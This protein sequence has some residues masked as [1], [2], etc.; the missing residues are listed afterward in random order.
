VSLIKEASNLLVGFELSTDA[1]NDLKNILLSGQ[2]SD[3]YWT[4]AWNAFLA[5]PSTENKNI[6]QTRLQ[7]MFQRLLQLGEF[8]LM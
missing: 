8:Q 6:I 3:Y 1:V 4:N 5:N 2:Q 7:Y